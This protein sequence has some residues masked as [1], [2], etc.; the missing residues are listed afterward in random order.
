MS[1]LV[2]AASAI[3]A[4]AQQR[5]EIAGRNVANATVPAY[6][7]QVAFT[8]LAS[9]PGGDRSDARPITTAVD[10]RPGKL[11]ETGNPYDLALGGAGFFAVA[12]EGGVR[13]TR[14]GR[15]TR[16]GD[17]RLVDVLGGVL[18]A[19]G[20]GDVVVGEGP[21]E[22]RPDGGVFLGGKPAGRVAVYDTARPQALVLVDGG[23]A[24]REGGQQIVEE[25]RVVQGFYEASNV[26]TADEMVQMMQALRSAE[27]GQRVMIAYDDLMGRVLSILGESVR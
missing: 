26:S 25:A 16:R 15:F 21:F 27:A 11:V 5:T 23:F 7:R 6:K 24:D 17:G 10:F 22:V 14:A 8:A 2:Q 20:G 13:F 3:L 18:Q 19:T 1:D 4:Q 9:A 12:D